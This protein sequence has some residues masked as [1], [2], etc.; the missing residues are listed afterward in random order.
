MHLSAFTGVVA[1][2]AYTAGS[3]IPFDLSVAN[4]LRRQASSTTTSVAPVGS[5]VNTAL[6]RNCWS[7]GFTIA[8]DFD[9]KW[10][11]TGK[12]VPLTFDI[13]H[14]SM[15]LDGND[16]NPKDV[17][18]INGKYPGPTVY[19]NWGDTLQITVN[20]K[21]TTEGAGFHWHG[22]RQYN[23]NQ[24]DGVPGVT[25]CPIAPGS[26]R[27]YSFQVTQYGTSW[28]HSHWSAQYG[29]GIKGAIV[30]N[31][32]A[33]QNYD[34]DMGPFLIQDYLYKSV[35]ELEDQAK[36]APPSGD[37]GLINGTMKSPDGTKGTYL[38]KT[39]TKGKK[40]RL[41]FI[42]TSV[43]NQFHVS[44]DNHIFTVVSADF[45]PV[46]PYQAQWLML[47]IG[48][49]Y[50]VVITANQAAGNYWFRAEVPSGGLC[51]ANQ[52][53]IGPSGSD[54]QRIRAIFSYD[55]ATSG[56]PNSTA[57]ANPRSGDCVDET[58]LAPYWD[59][60]VPSNAFDAFDHF[61]FLNVSEDPSIGKDAS[62][63]NVTIFTWKINGTSF[64]IDWN[65][66][67][68]DYV[69]TSTN[70]PASYNVVHMDQANAWYYWVIQQDANNGLS[71]IPHPIH[72]HGHDFYLLGTGPGQFSK[73]NVGGLNFGNPPRRDVAMLPSG[74]WLAFAFKADNPGAWLMHCHI[75]WHAS[76]GLAT[77][78]LEQSSAINQ[79]DPLK[80]SYSQTC[81]DW[82]AKGQGIKKTD[83]G[84]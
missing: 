62:G 83:S 84:I 48:Q 41:R 67:T 27:T 54:T 17:I 58:Q 39:L 15:V 82:R 37:N 14:A 21:L 70:A 79:A 49:R 71:F 60:F 73:S 35:F 3:A 64:D 22:I 42:N 12:T 2:A 77:Q 45:V 47:G 69:S 55:T 25:E 31:G 23:S 61:T 11:Q 52:A 33:T 81:S 10:P 68:R 46:K 8:T 6:T 34:I 5:C 18:T 36:S 13:D 16:T 78:F 24:E 29:D 72:L 65:H 66:P 80:S 43:D 53:S 50:D 30:I 76:G 63:N 74:G 75:A 40:Y 38:M 57:F 59:S 51:G 1:F 7:N 4:L 32:P 26:S 20:N 9:Q 19:A 56:T 44:L 28:Y